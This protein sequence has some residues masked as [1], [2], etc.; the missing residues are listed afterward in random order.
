MNSN[1]IIKDQDSYE[2]VSIVK[3]F[4]VRETARAV[5]IRLP[6]GK[7]IWFPRTTINSVYSKDPNIFQEFIID[8]WFLRKLG[9]IL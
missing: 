5:F 1:F 6:N 3:G 2:P 8:D 4:Y 7:Y 9:L